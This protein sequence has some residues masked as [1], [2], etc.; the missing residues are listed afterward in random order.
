MD[1]GVNLECLDHLL[2]KIETVFLTSLH[3]II[4]LMDYTIHESTQYLSFNLTIIL[5]D[6][7]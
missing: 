7:M 2:F 1:L 6:I 4:L 3:L 5:N